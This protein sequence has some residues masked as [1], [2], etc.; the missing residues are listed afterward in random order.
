M[1][2][3]ILQI[4]AASLLA[5]FCVSAVDA[6]SAGSEIAMAKC[7]RTPTQPSEEA[8]GPSDEEYSDGTGYGDDDSDDSYGDGDGA[9]EAENQSQS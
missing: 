2:R 8:V 6:P 4:A 7:S 3:E 5:L 1:N 9:P